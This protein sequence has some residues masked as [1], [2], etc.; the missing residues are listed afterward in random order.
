MLRPLQTHSPDLDRRE[1]VRKGSL[2]EAAWQLCEAAVQAAE[3]IELDA[4]PGAPCRSSCL[5]A[6]DHRSRHIHTS[7]HCINALQHMTCAAML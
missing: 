4:L 7:D 3:R 6:L 5:L 2:Q 1:D